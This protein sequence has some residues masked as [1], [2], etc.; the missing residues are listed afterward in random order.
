MSTFFAGLS[1]RKRLPDTIAPGM[2]LIVAIH[3]GTYTSAYFDVHGHSLLDR[4]EAL[5][6]PILAL[7]RPGYGESPMLDDGRMASQARFLTGALKEAWDLYGAGTSGMVIVAHS[8]GAAISLRIASEPDGLPLLGIAVSGVGLR[9]PEGH[10]PMWE[11]LPDLPHVDLPSPMKDEV[12]FGPPGS[13][14][15]D[16]PEASHAADAPA[17]RAEL[18]DIVSTWHHDVRD[19]LGKIRI[20][21]HYRQAEID[22]LWIVD[23]GE[24]DGFAAALTEAARVD[25]AMV[26]GTGHCMDFH[27]VGPALQLQQLGFALQCA[28]E[29]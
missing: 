11:A 4:A 19:V 25:A 8:I 15:P 3:G 24:V 27:R 5:G 10:Q 7:D 1:G 2:P 13:Y 17:L 29:A 26:R 6:I 9:T 23:Q 28:A 12:M 16:M 18:V 14:G 21:V 22:H 20:P